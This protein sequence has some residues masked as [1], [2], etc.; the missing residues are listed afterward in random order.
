[1]MNFERTGQVEN[2][3]ID[4]AYERANE[5]LSDAIDIRDFSDIYKD[6]D[7]DEAYVEMMENKFKETK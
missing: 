2:V 6:L 7:K 3:D 4:K 5:V 1:M